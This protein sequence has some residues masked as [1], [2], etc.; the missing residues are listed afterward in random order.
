MWSKQLFSY[1][2]VVGVPSA[3]L[4]CIADYQPRV[5]VRDIQAQVNARRT[6]S[7]QTKTVI[8]NVRVFDG[9]CLTTPQSVIF[10]DGHITADPAGIETSVDG[11]GKFLIPG[12]IDAHVHVSDLTSL[13]NITSYGVTSI[14]NMVCRTSYATCAALK[15]NNQTDVVQVFS[16]DSLV[17]P[18]TNLQELVA[19]A[20]GN[21]SDYYKLIAKPAS[22]NQS[23]QDTLVSTI[24]RKYGRQSMT[25]A[26]DTASYKQAI[27]SRT[28]GIQHIP[29]G[30]L[31]SPETVAAI[32][33]N[34]QYVTPTM[35][36]F[37]Y[38][39]THPAN[40]RIL[41]RNGVPILAGTDAVG[42]VTLDIDLPFG[43]SLHGEL[44]LLHGVGLSP[45]EALRAGTVET[46]RW[47]RLDD[48][49]KIKVGKR[50]GLVLLNS[51]PLVNISNTKDIARVWVA[52]VEVSEVTGLT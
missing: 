39:Y 7:P 10:A 51:N 24:Q 43:S 13:A 23:Q 49:G 31:L 25:H 35:S 42:A 12:L 48:R 44:E 30:G 9:E 46:A 5:T 14:L 34:G 45:L 1:A 11:T 29:D 8:H 16:A 40:V 19:F 26:A 36:V 6:P 18:N 21:G 28:N 33:A 50:A 20:F 38:G 47:H 17:Y 15:N 27:L 4:G 41:R 32:K 37:Q 2:A 22:L 52:G 3:T